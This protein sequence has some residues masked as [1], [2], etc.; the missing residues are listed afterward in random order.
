MLKGG[1]MKKI[2]SYSFTLPTIIALL[3]LMSMLMA[4]QKIMEKKCTR[5]HMLRNPD[6]YSK[7]EWKRHVER[8]AQRAGLTEEEKKS[9]IELNKKE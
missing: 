6:N 5:C 1:L 9:I 3:S 7:S 8:M 2:L 4:D